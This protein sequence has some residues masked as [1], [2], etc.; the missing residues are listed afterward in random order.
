MKKPIEP[1][2][3]QK[4]LNKYKDAYTIDVKNEL[5]LYSLKLIELAIKKYLKREGITVN[6]L[7]LKGRGF[8]FQRIRLK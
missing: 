2:K 8:L 7:T 6:Y 3:P 4:Y 5:G 1:I